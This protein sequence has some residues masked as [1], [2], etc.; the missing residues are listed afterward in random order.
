MSYNN[1]PNKNN[2]TRTIP[3][4]EKF[5][6]YGFTVKKVDDGVF[7]SDLLQKPLEGAEFH[8]LNAE[9]EVFTGFDKDNAEF[10]ENAENPFVLKS[11]ANGVIKLDGL[12]SGTYTLREIKAPEGY[13]LLAN[14]DTEIQVK[15]DIHTEGVLKDIENERNE[16]LPIT[17]TEQ[18]VIAMITAVVALGAAGIFMFVSR[19]KKKEQPIFMKKR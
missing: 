11:D 9:G 18:A 8:L 6:T 10:E 15:D 16:D 7:S 1:T 3:S 19:R 14:P 4:E 2:K 5:T 12:Q 17:G 13:R